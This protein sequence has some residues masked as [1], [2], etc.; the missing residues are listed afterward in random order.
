MS[1][2]ENILWFI[3]KQHTPQS[4]SW[5]HGFRPT[6]RWLFRTKAKATSFRNKKLANPKRS[7]NYTYSYP[8]KVVWGPDQ[9]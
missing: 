9:V 7:K 8:Q 6:Q 1:S 4:G 5:E 3:E 2:G